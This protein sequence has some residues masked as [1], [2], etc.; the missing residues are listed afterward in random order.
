M[1]ILGLVSMQILIAL[2]LTCIELVGGVGVR[3]SFVN[4]MFGL[5]SAFVVAVRYALFYAEPCYN[6]NRLSYQLC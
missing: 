2:Y 3:V 1:V 5:F 6:D 4:S